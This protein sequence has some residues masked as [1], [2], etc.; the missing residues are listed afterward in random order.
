MKRKYRDAYDAAVIG[1][2]AAIF[3]VI[4]TILCIIAWLPWLHPIWT[5]AV[6]AFGVGVGLAVYCLTPH[7]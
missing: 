1:V 7:E 6:V 3:A 2:F 4:I 5:I